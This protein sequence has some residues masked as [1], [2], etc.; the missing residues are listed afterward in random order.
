M[1]ID[2]KIVKHYN[3]G[4]GDIMRSFMVAYVKVVEK[5]ARENGGWKEKKT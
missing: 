4:C 3:K 5:M 2:R 1:Y